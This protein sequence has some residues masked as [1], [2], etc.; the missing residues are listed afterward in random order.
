MILI[1][2]RAKEGGDRTGEQMEACEAMIRQVFSDCLSNDVQGLLR[3]WY[4]PNS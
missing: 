3:F 2:I 1:R 4:L